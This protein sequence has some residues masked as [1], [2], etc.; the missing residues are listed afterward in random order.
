MVRFIFV[1][2]TMPLRMRPRIDTLP[3]K[4]HFLSTYEPS[5]ASLGVLKPR[6]TLRTYLKPFFDFF[7][8]VRLRPRK[9][10]SCFWYAFS[11][12]STSRCA[13]GILASLSCVPFSQL[14]DVDDRR[15]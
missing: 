8:S 7:A 4:G 5:S 15:Q 9:T 11:V 3:V 2:M 6:P 1:E 14:F 13:C 10:A 12:W